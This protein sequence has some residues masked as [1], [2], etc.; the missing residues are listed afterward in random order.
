METIL[1]D[2]ER[3]DNKNNSDTYNSESVKVMKD[4]DRDLNFF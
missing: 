2:L 3:L 4:F 1:L